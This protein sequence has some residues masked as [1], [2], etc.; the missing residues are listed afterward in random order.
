VHESLGIDDI[1]SFVIQEQAQPGREVVLG[2]TNDPLFGPLLMFGSG[3][4]T[5]EVFRDVAFR[6]LPL[7]D[8][9]AREMVRS[10]KGYAL[11]QGFRGDPPVDVALAE[12]ILQ[13]LAQLVSD[14]DCIAEM[15]INPFVL[16]PERGGCVAVD[17]RV[18]LVSA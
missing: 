18:I 2:V 9:D 16:T 10:I 14:F 11:L 4:R 8:V 17:V 1:E 5:V 6:V 3:G 15:D 12:E 7:T 13:R